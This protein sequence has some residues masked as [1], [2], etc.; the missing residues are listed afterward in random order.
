MKLNPTKVFL[1]IGYPKTGTT[2][3]QG[4]LY[5]NREKLKTYGYCYPMSGLIGTGKQ[6]LAEAMD[7]GFQE[8]TEN[9]FKADIPLLIDEM[10]STTLPNIIISNERF[11][12]FKPDVIAELK[13]LLNGFD[14]YIVMYLRRQD[15][16][17]Q[18]LWA[19]KC[20]EGHLTQPFMEWVDELSKISFDIE[21]ASSDV[22]RSRFP[23]NYLHVADR[24]GEIFG[25]D[26]IFIRPFERKQL[27]ANIL[28]DFLE[29]CEIED[30]SWI[31]D[32]SEYNVS[33]GPKLLE[34][35]R[36]LARELQKYKVR[37]DYKMQY[38]YAF[39]TMENQGDKLQW[40]TVKPSYLTRKHHDIIM[41]HFS[42]SNIKVAQKYLGK[43]QLFI[44]D[45]R[46]VP[47][48][49]IDSDEITVDD[50]INLMKPLF[51]NT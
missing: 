35:L 29:I 34:V 16:Y 8:D 13:D 38:R 28:A 47:I 11:A 10:H 17:L 5:I 32:V 50:V 39:H 7:A 4:G 19:Q 33:P 31:S 6:S 40:N 18:S 46:E 36:L 48:T 27:K 9:R 45:F 23:L 25:E 21:N 15:L 41:S 26:H 42:E 51:N 49:T 20:K 2:A 1:H 24:W 37:K 3:I 22:G 12:L 30:S 14:V 43:D 44:E